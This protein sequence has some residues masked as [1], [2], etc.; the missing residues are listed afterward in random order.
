[1]SLSRPS[2]RRRTKPLM[3]LLLGLLVIAVSLVVT[4][5]TSSAA[6]V[7]QES[8]SVAT[9]VT[10]QPVATPLATLTA[11]SGYCEHPT[12]RLGSRGTAV[13][14]AQRLINGTRSDFGTPIC[15]PAL[16]VDGRFGDKTRTAV[17]CIQ[18]FYG[19]KQD[20]IIGPITWSYLDRYGR[21]AEASDFEAEH[22]GSTWARNAPHNYVLVA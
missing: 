8:P 10:V 7:V 22:A 6:S 15:Q 20:G 13:S 5:G 9:T 2:S 21:A 19:L 3:A 18:R 4:S 11:A 1:M 16:T 17:I 14:C 12:L